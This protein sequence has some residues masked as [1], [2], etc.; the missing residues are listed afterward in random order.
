[1]RKIVITQCLF[2]FLLA[3]IGCSKDD[4]PEIEPPIVAEGKVTSVSLKAVEE[5]TGT[6]PA[7]FDF[8]AEIKTDGP[9]TVK[10]TWLRSDGATAPEETIT[11]DNAGS[12]TMTTS[13]TFGANGSSYE[14]NWQQLKIISPNEMLSNKANFNLNCNEEISIDF[15]NHLGTSINLDEFEYTEQGIESIKAVTSAA[16]CSDAIPVLL[17]EGTNDS[18]TSYL[19][20]SNADNFSACSTIPIQFIFAQ[21]VKKVVVEFFG[22]AV[23]YNLTVFDDEGTLLGNSMETSTPYEYETPSVISWE[24]DS[25]VISRVIFGKTGAVT[26]IRKITYVR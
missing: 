5:F 14:G 1:M 24:M 26:H 11:F 23:N 6:C 22:A 7:K 16:Y 17:E 25:K 9:M 12:K 2:A 21:P 4:S 18:P 8:E 3:F 19:G 10:Y 15:S 20:T 13:W